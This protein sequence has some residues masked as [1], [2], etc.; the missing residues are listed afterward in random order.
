M[1]T[2]APANAGPYRLI[3]IEKN[4]LCVPTKLGGYALVSRLLKRELKTCDTIE[5][6]A[7][8]R[9]WIYDRYFMRRMEDITAR[10]VDDVSKIGYVVIDRFGD[11]VPV[12]V[13][14]GALERR[15]A[16]KRAAMPT[17]AYR[18]GPVEGMRR[19]RRYSRW[20]RA[21]ATTAERRANQEDWILDIE[22]LEIHIPVRGRRRNLPD[23]WDD[24]PT[25]GLKN[26]NWKR[27][28]RTR[29]KPASRAN[30]AE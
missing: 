9:G 4:D 27:F 11:P 15:T 8:S 24:I 3:S 25:I 10:L 20:L 21:P 1:H 14:L 5:A 19:W 30:L 17:Y 28:R 18:N 6:L 23:A 7:A 12:G 16:A 13:L 26:R 29:W 2:H 22:D